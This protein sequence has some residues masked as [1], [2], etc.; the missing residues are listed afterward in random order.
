MQGVAELLA[1]LDPLPLECDGFV[2]AASWVLKQAGV[3][4]EVW[5]GTVTF[6]GQTLPY[7]MWLTLEGVP[8]DYRLRMW[9]GP[10]APHGV[11]PHLE[12]EYAGEPVNPIVNQIVYDILTTTS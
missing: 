1:H 9:F 5:A 7:H 10:A 8:V 12:V 3:P 6:Q 11:G 2:R 4:H